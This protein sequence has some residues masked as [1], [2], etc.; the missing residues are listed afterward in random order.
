VNK[1]KEQ[2]VR[3]LSAL[4]TL[5]PVDPT[6]RAVTIENYIN[7]TLA[8]IR[9]RMPDNPVLKGFKVYSQVDEDG[10]IEAI[11]SKL[12]SSSQTKNFIEIG[13]GRGIENNTHFLALKGY[14][15][16]WVDGS[17]TN[18]NFINS[19]LPGLASSK[20]LR[21]EKQFV[22]VSNVRQLLQSYVNFLGTDKI[23][24]FT[25]DIDGND[26]F[27]LAEAMKVVKPAI[28]CVEYNGKFPPTLS[29][30]IKRNDTH[31][32]ES[33]DYH[34]ATLPRFVEALPEY[35]LVCCSIAGTNA[36][37]VRNDL[38]GNFTKYSMEDLYR[39]ARYELVRRTSGH[40]PST[41]WLRDI[42]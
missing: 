26:V 14:R 20:K 25:L 2:L 30:S 19:Q 24:F 28:V 37:F 38:T 36:F 34:G 31:S 40:A 4:F 32:W 41:K 10:I 1:F 6:V 33:D 12:P 17:D 42:L 21:V 7:A 35:T 23:E 27:V 9:A 29:A 18:I 5:V 13:C 11:C 8:D 16:V 15:G 22:T 39:P 3:K